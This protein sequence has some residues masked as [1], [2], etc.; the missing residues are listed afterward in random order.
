M[1]KTKLETIIFERRDAVRRSLSTLLDKVE[2]VIADA[3]IESPNVNYIRVNLDKVVSHTGFAVKQ[4]QDNLDLIYT[5]LL[6][7]GY[8]VALYVD[9]DDDNSQYLVV[10]V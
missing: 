5:A 4:L 8:D 3:Y 1:S 6:D 10:S 2:G 9:E 7:K